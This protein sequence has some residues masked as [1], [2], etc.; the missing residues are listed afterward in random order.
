MKA[1]VVYESF[2]GNT[3]KVAE[4]IAKGLRDR[5]EVKVVKTEQASYDAL[6]DTELLIV[7]GPTQVWGMSRPLSRKA[8]RESL[9]E[10]PDRGESVNAD[11]G[12]REWLRDLP[13]TE[14]KAAAA[15][16]TRMVRKG[17]VPSGAAAK[18]IASRLGKAGYRLVA[19]A[20]GFLVQDTKGPLADGEEGRATQWG[21]RIAA[22][23]AGAPSD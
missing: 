11:T 20:E 19:D 12:V 22:V 8:A 15:F 5:F 23:A 2:F 18:G 13:K 6:K 1:L 10:A 9:A 3:R 21:R 7:G 14:G 4:A 17:V 16:D